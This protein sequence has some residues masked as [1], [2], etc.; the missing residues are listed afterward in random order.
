M[1]AQ[2]GNLVRDVTVT[3]RA[4]S[5]L[6]RVISARVMPRKDRSIYEQAHQDDS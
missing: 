5:T 6:I 1:D 2:R 4:E 3:P